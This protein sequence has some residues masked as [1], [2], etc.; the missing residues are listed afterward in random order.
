MPDY[1]GKFSILS[2]KNLNKIDPTAIQHRVQ[3][4]LNAKALP[5]SPTQEEY[6][7]TYKSEPR[8]LFQWLATSK[9][10]LNILSFG[11]QLLYHKLFLHLLPRCPLCDT[12]TLNTEYLFNKCKGIAAI[13]EEENHRMELAHPWL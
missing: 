8:K 6:F 1:K 4:S 12:P 10:R 3:T 13:I 11:W 2:K 9:I 7:H 5:L